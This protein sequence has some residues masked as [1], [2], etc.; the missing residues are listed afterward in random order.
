LVI[1]LDKSAAKSRGLPVFGGVAARGLDARFVRARTGDGEQRPFPGKDVRVTAEHILVDSVD[2]RPGGKALEV[3]AT[4]RGVDQAAA[5][6][7]A[8]E[9]TTHTRPAR[10]WLL[11]GAGAI[12]AAL[13][14][15]FG[16]IKAWREH[17][18]AAA[19]NTNESSP[20]PMP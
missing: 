20:D 11:H 2:L 4:F 19:P 6:A 10:A 17:K 7:G 1:A 13:T 18:S 14:F 3:T 12:G 8:I 16:V 9:M 5:V 15:V